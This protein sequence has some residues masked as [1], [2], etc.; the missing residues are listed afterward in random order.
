MLS[1]HTHTQ[2]LGFHVLWGLSIDFM[3]TVQTLCYI[4]QSPPS[5]LQNIKI[6]TQENIEE[7]D[8]N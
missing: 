6:S 2:M 1:T 7:L 8:V 3:R 4:M 5:H